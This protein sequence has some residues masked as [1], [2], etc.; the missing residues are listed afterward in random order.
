MQIDIAVE[1]IREAIMQMDRLSQRAS[2]LTPIHRHIGNIIQNSIEQSFEE[3]KSPFGQRWTASKKNRGK[4]LTDS[5]TLS[6]SFTV[7]ANANNV[8]VGTNLV[9][10]AVH[11]FGGNAGRNGSVRL[12]ARPFLPVRNGELEE[13]VKG[14][15]L[16]YLVERL[17]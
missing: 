16:D 4:T 2:N 1:G 6:G 5:G 7:S 17:S 13:G 3:E 15:I 10:G 12:P 9:Y 8:N 11:N 14:E